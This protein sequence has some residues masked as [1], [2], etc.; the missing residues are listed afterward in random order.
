MPQ[1]TIGAE[2]RIRITQANHPGDHFAEDIRKGLT[3]T[4]K[5]LYPKYL[6][7]KR[8]SELFEKICDLPEY[9]QTR[10]ERRILGDQSEEI[11][12]AHKPTTLIE[13]GAGAATK[14][15]TLLDAIGKKAN[16][17]TYIPIDVSA[18]FLKDSA[19][20]LAQKYPNLHIHGLTGDFLQSMELPYPEEPRLIAF[21]G[22]TIGNLNDREADAFLRRVA[23]Q[24]NDTDLF[25]LGVDLVKDI[26]ELEAAYNDK[27]GVTA[28]FTKNILHIIN[29]RL[30]ANFDTEA[31]QHHAFYHPGERQIESHLV[32]RKNQTVK[33]PDIDV[34]VEF[35]YGESIRV[36]ISG[37][38][39]RKRVRTLLDNAGLN[40]NGWYTDSQNRFA[41]SLSTLNDV[42][43]DVEYPDFTGDG[44][45]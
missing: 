36:E 43:P 40:Q 38:Y 34:E 9:Y 22:S 24:M 32:S 35:D 44:K 26:G 29:R 30:N 4:P 10:T 37:K 3:G 20:A 31:F 11:A 6:Y 1:T 33:I 17:Q 45:G 16:L 7:D 21:L 19:T 41:L 13:Y 27:Q 28:K 8:G 23:G 12:D 18:E 14:T 2:E 25:L 5:Y 42:T 39:T 15:R